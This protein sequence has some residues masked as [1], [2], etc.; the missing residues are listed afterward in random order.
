MSED[1]VAQTLMII[2][3]L[4]KNWSAIQFFGGQT[5]HTIHGNQY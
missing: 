3:S 1:P 2:D 5:N 4:K